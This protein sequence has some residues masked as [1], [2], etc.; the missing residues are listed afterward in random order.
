MMTHL[1]FSREANKS[2]LQKEILEPL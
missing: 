2:G 1:Q